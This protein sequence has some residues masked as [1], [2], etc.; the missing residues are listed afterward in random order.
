[1]CSQ[2][3]PGD[4]TVSKQQQCIQYADEELIPYV[5]DPH[6]Q[7]LI[8]LQYFVQEQQQGGDGFILFLD[9]NQDEHQSYRPQDHDVCFKTKGGFH[10]DGSIDGS[11]RTFMANCGL[12]NVLLDVHSD[13]FPNTHVR[14]SKQIDFARVTDEIRPCIKAVGLLDESILKIDHREIFLDLDLLLLFGVSLERLERPKF[15]EL[16]LDDPRISESYSKLLYTQCG[17]HNIYDRVQ[18]ISKRGKADDRSNE[19]E[20]CYEILDRDITA[21]MMRSAENCTI[22]KQ[23]DTPWAPSLSKA[24]HA[25]RYWTRRISRNSIQHTDDSVL[26]LFLEHSDLGASY[27]DKTMWVNDCVSEL[28]NAKAKFKDVHDEAT[29]NRDIYEVEVATARVERRYPYLIEDNIMQAQ[30]NGY[31]KRSSS[32]R[33]DGLHRIPSGSWDIKSES[34]SSP[35]IGKIQVL[36]DWMFKR[37]TV[38]GDKSSARLR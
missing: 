21:A 14:G 16:K 33:L 2:H 22:R 7:T 15:R 13:Q 38:S 25:I 20:R 31:K 6:K 30:E 5:L 35:I 27:S 24:T 34:M 3:D 19:D 1:V 36:I 4:T 28:R 23:H 9:A 37:R 32:E 8:D 12:T 10:V 29:S 26:D 11:L 18:K 17:R